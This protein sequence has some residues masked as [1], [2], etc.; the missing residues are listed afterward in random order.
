MLRSIVLTTTIACSAFSIFATER[1][2]DF[3][4]REELERLRPSLLPSAPEPDAPRKKKIGLVG[5]LLIYGFLAVVAGF[6]L[7]IAVLSTI[8]LC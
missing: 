4:P 7:L 1:R 3:E 5:R 2:F 8:P 6:G